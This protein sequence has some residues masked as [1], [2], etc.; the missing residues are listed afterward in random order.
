MNC[1][2]SRSTY[3]FILFLSGFFVLSFLQAQPQKEQYISEKGIA[4]TSENKRKF[5]YYFY[6]ALNA[7]ALGKFDEA[8]DYLQHCF[9]L[10]S[11]NANVLIELGTFYNVLQ[12]KNKAL[13]FYQKAV[14]YDR[15]NYYYNMMLAGLSKEMGQKQTVIDIYTF[16]LKQYPEKVELNYELANAYAD[17]GDL[18]KAIDALNELEKNMGISEAITLSKFRLYSMLDKKDRALKEIQLIIDK[19]P[20]DPRYLLLMGDIYLQDN[21]QA[22]ALQY[23]EQAKK[24][25]PELPAL[26]LS[27]VNYYERTNNKAA[28][29]GELQ[30]AITS[31]KLDV[32][33]KIQLLTRYLA[34]LQQNKQDIKNANSLFQT[35][36]DQHP[37]N[38]Q[39][40]LIYGNVL[41]LQENKKDALKQ[42]E[43]Y[44]KANPKDPAGYE[45]ILRLALPDSL[46]KV[47]EITEKAMEALPQEPQFYFYNGGAKLQQG[48]YKEALPIFERG[49]KNAVFENPLV[50]SDF[51]GQLGDIQHALGNDKAAFENYEKALKLNPQN[52]P[53]LNNYSYYLSLQRKEL[54]KAERMSGITVKAEPTNATY[55]DTYGWILFEQGAYT[56]AKIYIE[57][58]VEYGKEQP[59]AEV[60]EHYGDVLFKTGDKEKAVEQWKRAKEL[61]SDSKTLDKKIKTGEYIEK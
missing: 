48:K 38:T 37:N 60:Y 28:A 50:E 56:M 3:R 11:T 33:T 54:D 27:M 24:I 1:I 23:Y 51:Y 41:L 42:F 25:D 14:K 18:Q 2:V 7:K 31:S 13:D 6:D 39:L 26:T 57:K 58:A 45:Q 40:N 44:T 30:K 55:L 32:E 53:V 59:S 49:L 61:K 22:K 29:E 8:F 9:A 35:L 10:D 4:L 17:N 47:M 16:L 21:K 34:I 12:E 15:P 43:I 46:D 20:D 52:L 5:D 36:F 19:N